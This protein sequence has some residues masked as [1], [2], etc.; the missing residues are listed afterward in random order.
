V[1]F[2]L[3][4]RYVIIPIVIWVDRFNF[5]KNPKKRKVPIVNVYQEVR[6]RFS[7]LVSD[8][9]IWAS[10]IHILN[11][12]PLTPQEAI[13]NPER[14][15][16]P[17]LK[18]KEIMM[19]AEFRGSL[20]QAF[21]D[22]PG[23]FNGTLKEVFQ[24]PLENNF[25]R[26]VFISSIN[27]VLRHLGYISKTIH[28]RDREPAECATLFKNYIQ[29]KFGQPRI[30][31]IGLQPAMVESIALFFKIRVVDLDEESIGLIRSGILIEDVSQTQQILSWADM[32]IATGTTAVNDTLKNLLNGKPIIFYGVTISGTAYLMNYHQYC[33][34]SH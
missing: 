26:A 16:F 23:N 6:E 24:L 20:G 27:A 25:Q 8:N 12:R 33:P 21:T 22:M 34:C 19:Q 7:S 15:D 9:T 11:V 31:F 10:P 5:I 18:G 14:N 2:V 32:I 30:A 17:L 28:C 1:D 4:A 3:L 29:E 13:G